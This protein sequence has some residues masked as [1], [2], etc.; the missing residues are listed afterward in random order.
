MTEREAPITLA[1]VRAIQ[2]RALAHLQSNI[3][4]SEVG[5]ADAP[6]AEC[7]VFARYAL[8]LAR[9]LNTPETEDFDKAVP[10]EAAHQVARW[11]TAQDDGKNPEDWF[12][13]VGYLT[14]KALAAQKAGDTEKAKHHTISTAAALRN[15]HA[16]LRVG[17]SVMRPG[18]AEPIDVAPAPPAEGPWH[19]V[20][21]GDDAPWWM[22]VQG[23]GK[24]PCTSCGSTGRG[25]KKT[26]YGSPVRQEADAVCDALNRVAAGPAEGPDR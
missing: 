22:V 25:W 2:E 24:P 21:T 12:W 6:E 4:G 9:F 1:A 13:L 3:D 7:C 14:G 17:T 26:A 11:G 19:V 15:W 18:I 20:D 8:Q 16:H 23:E 10:L 5:V